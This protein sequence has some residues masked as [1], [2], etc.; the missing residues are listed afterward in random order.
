MFG[1]GA[2][3][4]AVLPAEDVPDCWAE[5][6]TFDGQLTAGIWTV[7]AAAA[8][9]ATEEAPIGNSSTPLETIPTLLPLTIPNGAEE[10]PIGEPSKLPGVA[11]VVVWPVSETTDGVTEPTMKE[12]EPSGAVDQDDPAAGRVAVESEPL[13][14]SKS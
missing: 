7:V 1:V 11:K 10:F 5:P 14:T 9:A 13:L 4:P 3:H 8:A 2:A 12:L 6:A